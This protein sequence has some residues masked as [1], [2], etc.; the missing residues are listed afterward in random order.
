VDCSSPLLLDALDHFLYQVEGD[1]E[2]AR[3]FYAATTTDEMVSLAEDSGILI[4]ADDFRALLRSGSTE[5]WLVRGNDST[6]PI[7]H[8]QQTFSV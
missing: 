5:R 3:E 8:L 1:P 2:F 6:N 7:I 4:D